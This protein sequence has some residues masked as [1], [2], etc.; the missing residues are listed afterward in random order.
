VLLLCLF[1]AGRCVPTIKSTI[2]ALYG[3]YSKIDFRED[4]RSV[5]GENRC[6][7]ITCETYFA[8][9]PKHDKRTLPIRGLETALLRIVS[10]EDER[11]EVRVSALSG[12]RVL[13][14]TASRC[15]CG[16]LTKHPSHHD[17]PIDLRTNLVLNQRRRS[18]WRAGQVAQ[19]QRG[20]KV[21]SLQHDGIAWR[22]WAG[23][24]ACP[25]FRFCLGSVDA[26]ALESAGVVGVGGI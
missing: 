25:L 5:K 21:D 16:C 1:N 13:P 10:F 3:V 22:L 18:L 17:I 9:L 15:L 24:G 26:R 4:G 2:N 20:A 14:L 7:E 11:R 6:V 12:A 19:D 23:D 8:M